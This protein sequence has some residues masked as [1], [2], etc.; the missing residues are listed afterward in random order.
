MTRLRH[1]LLCTMALAVYKYIWDNAF[2]APG[3]ASVT[4][5]IFLFSEYYIST[6]APT[7]IF[8]LDP[9]HE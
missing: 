9:L 4:S 5:N 2:R 8:N 1:Y 6:T 3:A 7:D